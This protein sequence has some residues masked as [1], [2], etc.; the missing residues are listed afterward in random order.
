MVS[1]AMTVNRVSPISPNLPR[2]D[3]MPA[4]GVTAR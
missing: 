2:S 1:A 4:G 3:S